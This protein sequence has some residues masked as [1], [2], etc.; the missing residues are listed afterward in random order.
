M[1]VPLSQDVAPM[2]M[3]SQSPT[4]NARPIVRAIKQTCR[5]GVEVILFLDLGM[6]PRASERKTNR[7]DSM[8]KANLSLSRVVRMKKSLIVYTRN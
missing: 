6:S 1:Y 2:L 5:R 8:I 7:Q 3:S 4:L